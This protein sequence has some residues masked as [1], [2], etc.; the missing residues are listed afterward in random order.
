MQ[1]FEDYAKTVQ[2]DQ[3]FEHIVRDILRDKQS[4]WSHNYYS[5]PT[6]QWQTHVSKHRANI[7]LMQQTINK[8]VRTLKELDLQ[9]ARSNLDPKHPEYKPLKKDE[10]EKIDTTFTELAKINIYLADDMK[11]EQKELDKYTYLDYVYSR[12]NKNMY[13]LRNKFQIDGDINYLRKGITFTFLQQ[14]ADLNKPL[15]APAKPSLSCW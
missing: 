11:D 6:S 14:Y 12:T 3:R 7:V 9:I 8:N 4:Q 5:N 1:S 13:A 15:P 10:F 2:P